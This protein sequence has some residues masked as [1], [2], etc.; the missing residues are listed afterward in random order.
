MTVLTKPKYRV[1]TMQEIRDLPWNGYTVASTFSGCG[2]SCLG[3]RMAGYKV[4][5]ALE[6]I[7]EAQRT[8]K[9]NHPDSY[10]DTSD[11]RDLQPEQLLERAGVAKGEL[12]I[13]DG[14]PPCSA[15]STA[16]SREKGWGK[17]KDYSDG[18]QRVDDLFY[19]YA[20]ILEGVQP[21]VFVAENVTGL[22]KGTAKGYF[23][24]IMQRL[25]DCGYN[26]SCKVLD[27]RWLGVPQ[28]RQRTIFIGVR[29]DLNL[30]PIHPSP[31]PYTYTVEEAI[32]GCAT[33]SEDEIRSIS[34][35]SKTHRLWTK[36]RPGD[37]FATA[38]EA[39]T[40]KASFFNM[41]KVHPRK[42]APTITATCQHF[43]WKEWR[44]LTIPEVKRLCG[45]PDDFSLTG[46]F[47]KR[48]E[49][50]GR[51]VPPLMMKQ[52]AHTIDKEIL[53]CVA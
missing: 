12:D 31:F 21:K 10:L 25:R 1:P 37:N 17:V 14:S 40:G 52:V 30:S 4:A 22:V 50:V 41:C 27:A 19:E 28:A 38:C 5:Y 16:G 26:V 53:S 48:W 39:E 42:P 13:L 32:D 47:L 24:R 6:F 51:A 20:R 49:R 18:A 33:P 7:P 11:I 29:N 36:T 45:F 35:E 23:K 3:Y 9:A 46:E 15:F 43:H 34:D 8:Y 44:Y 2:G